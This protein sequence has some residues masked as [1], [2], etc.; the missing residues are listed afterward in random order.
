MQEGMGLP[1]SCGA[2]KWGSWQKRGSIGSPS[3]PVACSPSHLLMCMQT[4][5][6]QH[7]LGGGSAAHGT[8]CPGGSRCVGLCHLGRWQ[9][10]A[11]GREEGTFGASRDLP[12]LTWGKLCFCRVRG[13][14]GLGVQEGKGVLSRIRSPCS[15]SF[16]SLGTSMA[17]SL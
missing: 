3:D 11:A 10:T 13:S 6:T 5:T 2:E 7:P 17:I 16:L 4:H 1:L 15:P 8:A 14:C 12:A 9:R